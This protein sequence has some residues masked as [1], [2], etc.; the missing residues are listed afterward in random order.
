[1]LS[2]TNVVNFKP[3][4]QHKHQEFSHQ[5]HHEFFW[6]IHLMITQDISNIFPHHWAGRG[7]DT[8]RWKRE[9]I[10]L[11]VK[12][13]TFDS[14]ESVEQ[15][16]PQFVP[17]EWRGNHVK[18]KEWTNVWQCSGVDVSPGDS[19]WCCSQWRESS[20]S[21]PQ[22]WRWCLQDLLLPIAKSAVGKE[23]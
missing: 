6:K 4:G 10:I 19:D 22:R 3:R 21:I 2:T 11:V 14:K 7:G 8:I 9:Y 18:Y 5:W 16:S 12:Q 17:K 15:S 1:M 20:C 23:S 13:T